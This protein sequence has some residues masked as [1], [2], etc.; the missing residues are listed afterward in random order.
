[1]AR[2]SSFAVAIASSLVVECKI[3]TLVG[4]A[5]VAF[6]VDL[7]ARKLSLLVFVFSSMLFSMSLLTIVS[8]NVSEEVGSERCVR[9]WNY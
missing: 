4:R 8:T 1:M 3:T 2:P 9:N 6:K 5:S 7:A